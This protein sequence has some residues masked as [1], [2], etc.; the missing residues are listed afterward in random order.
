MRSR[1]S[2]LWYIGPL[3]LLPWLRSN[4][5]G[6]ND[7]DDENDDDKEA[8][9]LLSAGAGSRFD[10]GV[11]LLD[12]SAG[13][14]LD[15]VAVVFDLLDHL[16]LL[17]DEL[18]HV[19]EQLSQFDHCPLDLLDIVVT[20]AN[21]RQC[22]P[23]SSRSLTGHSSL[24]ENLGVGIALLDF[25]DILIRSVWVGDPVL[26]HNLFPRLPLM[27]NLDLLVSVDGLLEGPLQ[28]GDLAGFF[29]VIGGLAL[30][31]PN[32]IS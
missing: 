5:N 6:N 4:N 28:N 9:P 2:Q 23:R 29:G 15:L 25:L 32:T 31:R 8:P 16:A 20:A 12:G 30:Q 13:V 27:C 11:E 18:I 17:D 10:R 19:F 24:A 14:F 7:D 26:S 22:G 1:P 3:L 21:F